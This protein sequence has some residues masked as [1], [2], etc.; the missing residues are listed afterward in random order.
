MYPSRKAKQRGIDSFNYYRKHKDKEKMDETIKSCVICLDVVEEQG[1][2]A[3]CDHWFCFI[4]IYEWSKRTNTCPLCKKKFR[5]ISKRSPGSNGAAKIYRIKDKDQSYQNESLIQDDYDV[6]MGLL[7]SNETSDDDE[8]DSDF[9]ISQGEDVNDDVNDDENNDSPLRRP[10]TRRAVTSEQLEISDVRDGSSEQLE[11][12]DENNCSSDQLETSDYSDGNGSYTN[13]STIN[14]ENNRMAINNSEDECSSNDDENLTLAVVRNK[15]NSHRNL[16]SDENSDSELETSDDNYNNQNTHNLRSKQKSSPTEINTRKATLRRRHRK[17]NTFL[18]AS[19]NCSSS[20]DDSDSYSS[21]QKIKE[22]KLNNTQEICSS[23][24]HPLPVTNGWI[25]VSNKNNYP[26][27]RINSL[28][29]NDTHNSTRTSNYSLPD[30]SGGDINNSSDQEFSLSNFTKKKNPSRKKYSQSKD[31]QSDV[32]SNSDDNSES[33]SENI[34]TLCRKSNRQKNFQS[35]DS[36]T[37]ESITKT[38]RNRSAKSKAFIQ[39]KK[40]NK[41]DNKVLKKL[42]LSSEDEY[43]PY[44]NQDEKHSINLKSAGRPR[45]KLNPVFY[46]DSSQSELNETTSP[47]LFG[48]PTSK[49]KRTLRQR[50]LEATYD[51][52]LTNSTKEIESEVSDVDNINNDDDLPL[53]FVK[54]NRDSYFDISTDHD[55]KVQMNKGV[56]R[57]RKDSSG[58]S[59]DGQDNA[60]QSSISSSSCSNQ[61]DLHNTPSKNDKNPPCLLS[62]KESPINNNKKKKYRFRYANPKLNSIL[63]N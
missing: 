45:S 59:I 63:C 23:S 34:R 5:I 42:H 60:K 20:D 50:K 3:A 19:N 8:N 1:A 29:R 28:R 27:K 17:S 13:L 11:A 49:T 57:L 12:S 16:P 41:I 62:Q 38:I 52:N 4:C 35:D 21:L 47:I 7:S 43:S 2:L 15:K 37:D 58:S 25:D 30:S 6:A 55:T 51:S 32:D 24:H 61:L 33:E 53:A 40:F 10:Q 48:S 9:S 39:I 56:K 36:T 44:E 14:E 31:C 46:E 18:G 22:Y 54:S 26:N